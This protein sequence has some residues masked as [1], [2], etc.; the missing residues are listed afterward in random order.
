MRKTFLILLIIERRNWHVACKQYSSPRIDY[1]GLQ[2]SL[3]L[4]SQRSFM[5]C[6]LVCWSL[7][8]IPYGPS[9]NQLYNRTDWSFQIAAWQVGIVW[10]CDWRAEALTHF[11]S[12]PG[13]AQLLAVDAAAPTW[14]VQ[15][16]LQEATRD[17]GGC[18]TSSTTQ[19]LTS[20]FQ[21]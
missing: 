10:A 9:L 4:P 5:I 14:Q 20:M 1:S 11:S 6:Y 17:L 12:S 3:W 15:I 16:E 18:G 19:F 21:M 7:V 8:K 2:N 13:V